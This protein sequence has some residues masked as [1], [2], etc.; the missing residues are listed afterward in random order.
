[1]ILTNSYWKH[2][3]VIAK[4]QTQMY[5]HTQPNNIVIL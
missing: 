1:M 4:E 2:G 5:Q 3:L